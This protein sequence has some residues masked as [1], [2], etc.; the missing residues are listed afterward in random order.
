MDD[1]QKHRCSGLLALQADLDV[2][3][4]TAVVTLFADMPVF[5]RE[6][7]LCL[8]HYQNL[9]EYIYNFMVAVLLFYFLRNFSLWNSFRFTKNQEANTS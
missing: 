7:R 8:N 3:V 6:Q 1:G 5:F 9:E 4:L 2:R